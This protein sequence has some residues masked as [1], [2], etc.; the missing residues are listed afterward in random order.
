MG[1][2]ASKGVAGGAAIAA[3][4]KENSVARG[5]GKSPVHSPN[6]ALRDGGFCAISFFFF[7]VFSA[8]HILAIRFK[9]PP[10]ACSYSSG[11]VSSAQPSGDR[12]RRDD[13]LQQ[14]HHAR[15]GGEQPS[16]QA[17]VA[18]SADD[19][20]VPRGK[21]PPSPRAGPAVASPVAAGHGED[22]DFAG[23]Y[24]APPSHGN[25]DR[26]SRCV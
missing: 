20:V 19:D 1:G 7:V 4:D 17:A 23:S 21:R 25:F 10:P 26:D 15:S 12:D 9:N 2:G 5:G 22:D 14:R 3:Y 8:P 18:P 13:S 16:P 24:E 6:Q 11:S